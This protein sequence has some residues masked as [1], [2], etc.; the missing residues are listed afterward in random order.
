MNFTYD[1]SSSDTDKLNISK[2][3]LEI[4]DT[5][6]GSGVKPDGS[7]LLDDEIAIW[8]DREDDDVMRAVAAACEALARYWAGAADIAVGPRRESLSQIAK[9]YAER[10]K[11][12]RQIHGGTAEG[13]FSAG[14][15]RVDGFSDDEPSDAVEATATDYEGDFRY[16]RPK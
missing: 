11:E 4:G 5:V 3:R 7:N 8:L 6:L 9:G 2:V 10:A 14:V 15:I 12:L 13:A 16:V 1:L